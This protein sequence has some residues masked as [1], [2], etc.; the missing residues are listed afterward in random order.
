MQASNSVKQYANPS[1]SSPSPSPTLS[2]LSTPSFSS[3]PAVFFL[4]S[5]SYNRTNVGDIWSLQQPTPT[6]GITGPTETYNNP[7]FK[8]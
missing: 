5:S 4:R 6:E 2:T 1:S 7:T 3:H 8:T